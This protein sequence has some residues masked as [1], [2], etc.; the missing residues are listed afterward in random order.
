MTARTR[1]RLVLLVG[2]GIVSALAVALLSGGA[3]RGDVS[4]KA[5]ILPWLALSGLLGAVLLGVAGG[6]LLVRGIRTG[7]ELGVEGRGSSATR[8][9]RVPAGTAREMHR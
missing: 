1:D 2:G 4:A 8:P 7:K 5:P 9:P 6:W 3:W